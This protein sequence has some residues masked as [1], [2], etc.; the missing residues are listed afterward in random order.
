MI[1]KIF[2]YSIYTLTGLISIF[3]AF[4]WLANYH[5]AEIEPEEVICPAN[6]PVLQPG[7]K[8]KVLNWNLQYM[9]GK[10]YVFYYDKLDGSGQDERPSAKDIK[11]T[12]SEVAR[13]IQD[14]KPDIILLQEL[15][16][17]SKRTDYD[18]QLQLLLKQISPKYKCYT[19]SF[20]HKSAFVPHP[21]IMG[22]VGMK[23]A[24]I[25]KYKISAAARHQLAFIPSNFIM[26]QFNLKRAI[27]HA[28]LPI[29]G[30]KD[31]IVM[32]THLD[33]FSQG[34][35]TMEMQIKESKEM[36]LA[37]RKNGNPWL[38]GGDFNLLPPGAYQRMPQDEKAYYKPETELKELYGVFQ[39]IPALKD[40]NSEQYAQWFTHF[41]NGRASGPDRTIDYIFFANSLQIG[42]YYVRQKDTL[43]ISDH[44]PVVANFTLPD[45]KSEK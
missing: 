43:K 29:Q 21:R 1:K 16:E 18:D 40:T 38:Y 32:N 25:S 35:N 10:N 44:L 11:I 5:P 39:V 14:E 12:I 15:D 24:T 20:Y 30:S 3:F 36:M 37:A 7:Q 4:V 22:S 2:R 41:P 28:T 33:A 27:L 31:L 45:K 8:I 9:S 34:T 13:I 42:D 6:A 23:M 17:N 19:D 26:Q